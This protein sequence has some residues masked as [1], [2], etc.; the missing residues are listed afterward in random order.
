[1]KRLLVLI[2]TLFMVLTFT[3]CNGFMTSVEGIVEPPVFT[4]EQSAIYDALKKQVGNNIQLIYPRV[5]EYRSAFIMKN[6]DDEPTEEAIVFYQSSFQSNRPSEVRINILDRTEDG[7]WFSICDIVG[8]GTEIDQVV[9]ANFGEEGDINLVVGYESPAA[10]EKTLVIYRYFDDMLE[11]QRE[12]DYEIFTLFDDVDAG[13]DQLFFIAAKDD[14][15]A[16]NLVS[17]FGDRY[18]IA[19][20]VFMHDKV[21]RYEAIFVGEAGGWG[22][23]AAYVDGYVGDKLCTQIVTRRAE[24][25]RN[26]TYNS[27][28]DMFSETFRRQKIFTTDWNGDGIGEVP[29]EVLMKGHRASDTN[30]LYYTDWKIFVNGAFS[31]KET[32]YVNEK[33]GYRLVIPPEWKTH[34]SAQLATDQDEIEFHCITEDNTREDELLR[35]RIGMKS[36][37]KQNSLR[38]GYFRVNLTGQIVYMAKINVDTDCEYRLTRDQLLNSFQI[39][40]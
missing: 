16:A 9:F 19:S 6:I 12:Y 32:A 21:D 27:E 1:M 39:L 4:D 11:T 23:P 31:V 29:C 35:L 24:G 15:K 8:R 2:L 13:K 7:K 10:E 22:I 30:A 37:I 25:L 38:Q 36:D 26:E 5:G 18:H 34:V 33:S 40:K 28:V 3:G 17:Y 14:G 20:T